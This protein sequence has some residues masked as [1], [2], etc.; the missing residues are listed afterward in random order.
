M[1][2]RDFPDAKFEIRIKEDAVLSKESTVFLKLAYTCKCY[3][4]RPTQYTEFVKVQKVKGSIMISD[5]IR[6]M[7]EYDVNPDCKHYFLMGFIKNTD[8]QFTVVFD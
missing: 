8:V 7:I 3:E 5:A 6:A 4:V 2:K 1:M